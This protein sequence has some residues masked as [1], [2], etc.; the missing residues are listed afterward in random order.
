MSERTTKAERFFELVT[1]WP[2][3]V[4]VLS[5][6]SIAGLAFFV[7]QIQK[8]TSS[9]A[10]IAADDPV[11]LYRDHVRDVFGLEDP[12]VVAVINDGSEGIFNPGSLALVDA[13]TQSIAK[14]SNVDPDRVTSLATESNIVGT[15]DG[16]EVSDFFDPYPHTQT[17]S[18]EIRDAISAFPLY[19]GALVARDGNATLIVAELLDQTA[20]QST[21]D[22]ILA[23]VA[24][25]PTPAGN[26][27]HVA[28]EGAISGYLATYIDRDATR[29]NPLAD[30]CRDIRFHGRIWCFFLRHHQRAGGNFDRHCGNRLHP[31]HEPGV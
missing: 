23:L 25:T 21:Y 20:A 13:L 11:V 18:D 6:L 27:V 12:I 10:F 31:H 30:A 15:Y 26:E 19:Q 14:L 7:P 9:D 16:M 3:T 2:K 22:E 1:V 5:L 17:R 24:E 4:L 29:L 28:G 8:D